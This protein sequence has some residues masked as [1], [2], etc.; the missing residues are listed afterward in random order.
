MAARDGPPMGKAHRHGSRDRARGHRKMAQAWP[1]RLRKARLE[2]MIAD[3]ARGTL[4]TGAERWLGRNRYFS[5]SLGWRWHVRPL[6]RR[7]ALHVPRPN[8][9]RWKCHMTRSVDLS[10]PRRS[11]DTRN[12]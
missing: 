7:L 6:H 2:E 10:S 4:A 11:M 3:R 9:P 1:S 5:Q 12:G 8:S